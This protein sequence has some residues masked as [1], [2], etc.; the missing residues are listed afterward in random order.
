MV[1]DYRSEKKE[2]IRAQGSNFQFTYGDYV[3]KSLIGS[4]DPKID[5]LDENKKGCCFVL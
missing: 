2:I 4:T 1:D 3:A 5:N